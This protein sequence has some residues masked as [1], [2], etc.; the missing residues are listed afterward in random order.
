MLDMAASQPLLVAVIAGYLLGSFP[1]AVL[2]CRLRGVDIFSAGSGLAGAANVSRVVGMKEGVAVFLV[3]GAKGILT[4]GVAHR[5]GI[6][7][8]M[9][10]L[11]AFSA[12][13]GHW[14]PVF[15]RFRGGDGVSTLIGITIAVLPIYGLISVVTALAAGLIARMS[16]QPAPSLW[17][18]VA[19][20]GFMILRLPASQENAI[21]VLGIV[22]LAVIVL[23]H[24]VM[25]HRRRRTA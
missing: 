23:A 19:G 10:L 25:G 2:I 16:G 17:G 8:E 11:P 22:L 6:D 4:I 12:L 13:V 24:G 18:G 5:L 21:I 1:T 15:T 14:R 3:D 20:Y 9:V 7:G